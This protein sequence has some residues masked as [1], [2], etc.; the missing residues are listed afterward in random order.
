MAINKKAEMI[1]GVLKREY[2]HTETFLHYTK[3]YEL[4]FAVILSAQATDKSVNEAT[5]LLFR[6][7]PSL[8]DYV[9]EKKER[10]YSIIKRIGLAK[11]KT[12]YIL[13]TARMLKEEYKGILPHE[14][15]ELMKFPGVG[16]KTSGVVLAE[17][18]IQD[19][20]PVDTHVQR[21][22]K[23]LGLIKKETPEETE[24]VLERIFRGS[25]YIVLHRQFILFARNICKAMNPSCETC[26]LKELC[27]EMKRK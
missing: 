2:P 8:D 26:P 21:V 19:F 11:S 18:G 17:L 10:I 25:E 23:R 20:F 12:E 4:L 24:K 22:S 27:T 7:F 3:D 15:K 6:E 9:I 14:R 16:Y 1:K 13:S 5:S